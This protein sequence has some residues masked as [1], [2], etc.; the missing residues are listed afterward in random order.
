MKYSDAFSRA[1]QTD[2]IGHIRSYYRFF[3]KPTETEFLMAVVH[4]AHRCIEFLT[5]KFF[6]AHGS[7]S[8]DLVQTAAQSNRVDVLRYAKKS[9]EW[10]IHTPA[11]GLGTPHLGREAAHFL[12]DQWQG[13]TTA[14]V[15]N[16][17]PNTVPIERPIFPQREDGP[18]TLARLSPDDELFERL[19]AIS[20]TRSDVRN[21]L[22]KQLL[23]TTRTHY[24]YCDFDA[25]FSQSYTDVFFENEQF[26]LDLLLKSV[27][28]TFPSTLSAVICQPQLKTV[29]NH[30]ISDL[31]DA[32]FSDVCMWRTEAFIWGNAQALFDLAPQIFLQKW[33]LLY[34]DN[35]NISSLG[36]AFNDRLVQHAP[37]AAEALIEHAPDDFVWDAHSLVGSYAIQHKLKKSLGVSRGAS[38]K[39]KM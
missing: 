6:R 4:N 32:F 17:T 29:A 33:A 36:N 24:S 20:Q 37:E 23:A 14:C 1:I 10:N 19:V 5:P 30:H 11:W 21:L 7:L 27:A 25:I 26:C 3:R 9:K 28:S 8:F 15:K 34:F 38:P 22:Q 12:L 18:F 39:R 2:D 35:P 13:C 16:W 31:C